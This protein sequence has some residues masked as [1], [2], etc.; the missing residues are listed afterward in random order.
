LAGRINDA[1]AACEQAI[2]LNPNFSAAYAELG[3][4]YALHGQPEEAIKACR[5]ALSLNPRDPANW[6]R[7]ATLA[8]AHFVAGDDEAALREAKTTARVRPELPEASIMVAAAA[9]ALGKIEEAQRAITLCMARWPGIC[10]GNVMPN[11]IPRFTRDEDRQRL[12]TMLR[13]AGLPE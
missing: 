13:K 4:K 9:A 10:L 7:H 6:E 2:E 3:R 8:I 12:L 1:A 11:Y 5:T